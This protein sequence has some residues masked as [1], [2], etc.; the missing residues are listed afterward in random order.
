MYLSSSQALVKASK[1]GSNPRS[2]Y[3]REKEPIFPLFKV[4]KKSTAATMATS[5]TAPTFPNANP[6]WHTVALVVFFISLCLS[7]LPKIA[8]SIDDVAT[9]HT[10]TSPLFPEIIS[11]TTLGWVRFAIGVFIFVISMMLVLM[12]ESYR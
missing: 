3:F 8:A 2:H 1:G 6:K 7:T 4:N 11:R 9:I 5:K 12:K 10:C